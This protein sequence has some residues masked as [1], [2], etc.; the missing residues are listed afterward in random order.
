GLRLLLRALAYPHLLADSQIEVALTGSPSPTAAP[1]AFLVRTA[2]DLETPLRA[3]PTSFF[4]ASRWCSK[5]LVVEL[6]FRGSVTDDAAELLDQLVADWVEFANFGA[7]A[8]EDQMT[9]FDPDDALEMLVD[10]PT[11]G[12]D[13][14]EWSVT[15]LEVAD[16]CQTALLN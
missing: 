4:M 14:L 2:R 1:S 8:T 12:D 15:R 3:L 13:F 6:T 9:N 7:Y 16:E 10:I 5:R 11:V